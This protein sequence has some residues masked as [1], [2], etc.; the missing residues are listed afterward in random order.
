[1]SLRILIANG[2]ETVLEGVAAVIESQPD[3]EVADRARDGL[4]A[5]ESARRLEPE[6]A[7]IG[8]SM[9]RLS[10]IE[11]TRRIAGER[12]EI[13]V[14]CLSMHRER[15]Y[16]SAALEAGAVGYL[17]K[18]RVSEHLIEAIRCVVGGRVYLCPEVRRGL[19]EVPGSPD[20]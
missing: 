2:H 13:R 3:M 9:P 18:D 16:A 10:G 15:Q 7:V 20:G 12:P 17:L 19:V 11:A 8:L 4:A 5:V 1:M 14:V 6:V